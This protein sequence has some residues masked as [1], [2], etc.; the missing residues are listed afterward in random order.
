MP[1][2][3]Q[4]LQLV[5]AVVVGFFVARDIVLNGI[6]IFNQHWVVIAV[7]TTLLLELALLVIY[8]LIEDD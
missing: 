4:F 3:V 6:A 1:R 7:A 8:K 5:I 2:F